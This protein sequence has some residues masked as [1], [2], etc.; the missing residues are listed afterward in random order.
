LVASTGS[1]EAG[2]GSSKPLEPFTHAFLRDG[3]LH[4]VVRTWFY[5]RNEFAQPYLSVDSQR[6]GVLHIEVKPNFSLVA[7]KCE[8]LRQFEVAM[9]A[10]QW[11]T[12]TT[13]RIFNHDVDQQVTAL[14]VADAT[15]MRKLFG[16]SKENVS[17]ASLEGT[18][19]GC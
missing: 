2:I 11:T 17:L 13:L 7:N 3:S 12:L 9:P 19:G 1:I 10:A 5:R 8:F 4:L 18:K 14:A 16:D 15:Y 6:N